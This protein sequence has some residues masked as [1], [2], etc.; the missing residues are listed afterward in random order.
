MTPVSDDPP[1]DFVRAPRV[2]RQAQRP[3]KLGAQRHQHILEGFGV[4]YGRDRQHLFPSYPRERQAF[5]ILEGDQ[6]AR[7]VPAFQK[8]GGGLHMIGNLRPQDGQAIRSD[9]G[10]ARQDD[11]IRAL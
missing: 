3:A 5:S 4:P 8:S 11:G 10:G 1:P 2:V 7:F 6:V 9:G